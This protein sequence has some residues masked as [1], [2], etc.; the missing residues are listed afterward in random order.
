MFQLLT[1]DD[2]A[3]RG[4]VTLHRGTVQTPVFMPV[5]TTGAIKTILPNDL[6]GMGAEIILANTYHMFLRPGMEV[7]SHFGGLHGFMHWNRPIL[8]DS[9]GFQL[10]SLSK[11][12]KLDENGAVFKSHI[13]GQ[14]FELSPERAVQI[15]EAFGS[16]IHMVLDECTSHPVTYEVARDSM[17]RSM[18]WA[19]R[20]REARAKPHLMQFGIVQGNVFEDLRIESCRSL[21][22]IGFDGY[23]IGGLSVGEHKGDMRAMT[24]LSCEHLPENQAR[25]LMGV[26]TPLD[27]IESVA[28]GVDMFDCVMPSRNARRGTLFTS[29]GKINIKNQ[30]HRADTAPLDANCSCYTCV[31]FSRAFL[32]HMFYA[33]E[34][35]AYRL[36]TL[37]NLTYYLN[38]MKEIRDSIEVGR[39]AQLLSSHRQLWATSEQSV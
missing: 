38:L 15:Q 4:I 7:L 3:R 21:V 28:L 19:K 1:Q 26:G 34:V 9:G 30:R 27:L 16:D 22:E 10:F 32:R 2:K 17:R 24:A 36:L 37:H 18:R 14:M 35:T 39:F 33:N 13:D 20:C 5:A 12:S 11:F 6:E 25:Y 31:S 29:H 8:T 23:A